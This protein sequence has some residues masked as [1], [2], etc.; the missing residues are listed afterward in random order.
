MT[1]T[2]HS[3]ETK[4]LGLTRWVQ[5][6]FLVLFLFAFWVLDKLVTLGWSMLGEPNPML[7]SGASA[8]IAG[9]AAW[10]LYKH[11]RIQTWTD[12]VV[13]ELARVAWPSRRETSASTLV[14]VIA[15]IVAAVIVGT[16]DAAWSAITDLIYKT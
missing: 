9:V 5:V 10:R 3:T 4:V 7:A 2:P 12:E 15:S 13:G 1:D 14:V 16:F 8:V 11:P 6:V